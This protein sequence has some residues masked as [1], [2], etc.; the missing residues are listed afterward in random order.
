MF[1]IT[2][3]FTP[4]GEGDLGLTL[5]RKR[6]MLIRRSIVD[7]SSRRRERSETGKAFYTKIYNHSIIG[8][9]TNRQT[10][11]H[12][13][14]QTDLFTYLQDFIYKKDAAA[15][16]YYKTRE[17]I[18]IPDYKGFLMLYLAPVPCRRTNPGG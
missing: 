18:I 4:H 3:D 11:R 15:I 9:Q 12:S 16:D 2:S 8:T 6:V 17:I 1:N 13:D 14:R 7:F 5:S 10:N